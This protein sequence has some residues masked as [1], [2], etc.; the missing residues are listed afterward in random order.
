MLSS[1]FKSLE[2]D[3]SLAKV[4]K[5]EKVRVYIVGD[6]SKFGN[7]LFREK[8]LKIQGYARRKNEIW[9]L[10]RRDKSNR[11]VLNPWV[12]GHELQHLLNFK[13][14]EIANPDNLRNR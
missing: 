3:P 13:E 1:A 14:P 2:K 9:I 11:I 12:L 5:L 10:G 8:R 6:S 7:H 4:I